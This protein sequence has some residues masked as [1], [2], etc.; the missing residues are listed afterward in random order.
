MATPFSKTCWVLAILLVPPAWADCG[1][2]SSG[3]Q[4]FS[5]ISKINVVN[6]TPNATAVTNAL[7]AATSKWN[8]ACNPG[9]STNIPELV[10][11]GSGE[12]DIKI[13]H[14]SGQVG[15]P[16]PVGTSGCG[17]ANRISSSGGQLVDS[18]VHIFDTSSTSTNCVG[19]YADI[20][21]HEFGH[22][23][24][25][26]NIPAACRSNCPGAIM[27]PWTPGTPRSQFG[28]ACNAAGGQFDVPTDGG[29]DP[30]CSAFFHPDFTPAN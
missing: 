13:V 14:H 9:T 27:G 11:D 6:T 16:C 24:Q 25:M 3:A 22:S 23:L 29:D 2:L 8:N 28:D 12:V 4:S 19:D 1:A 15:S 18:T 10:T 5:N 30:G 26:K 20:L 7:G 17:C 21:A